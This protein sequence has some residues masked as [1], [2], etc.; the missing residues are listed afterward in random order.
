M[1]QIHHK[2]RG[3][4]PGFIG[5]ELPNEYQVLLL[6]EDNYNAYRKHQNYNGVCMEVKDEYCH[7]EKPTQGSW[8]LV[9]EGKTCGFSSSNIHIIYKAA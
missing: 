7:F 8:H 4:Y 2:I 5:I 9:I 6:D 1:N 3:S